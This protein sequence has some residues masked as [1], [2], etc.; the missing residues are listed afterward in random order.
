ALLY[1]KDIEASTDMYYDEDAVRRQKS[2]EQVMNIPLSDFELSA[3]SRNCL[4]GAGILTLGDLTEISEQELLNS[5]NFGETSLVEVREIL[6]S[7]GLTIG[8]SVQQTE[9]RSPAF[10]N[11]SL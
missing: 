11:D 1:L 3:R 2:L 6:E 8:Q 4:D 9:T 5:K 7:K 10:D